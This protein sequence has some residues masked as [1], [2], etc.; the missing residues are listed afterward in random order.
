[1]RKLISNPS[2]FFLLR[3][4]KFSALLIIKPVNLWLRSFSMSSACFV[5]METRTE[6][7]LGSIRTLS[8]SFLA[9]VT[10]L[11]RSSADSLTST[12]GLLCLSTFWLEKLLRHSAA[13]S[14]L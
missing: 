2:I 9:M 14:V 4:R 1:M 8:L 11:R 6:L 7:M 12:A 10:G 3:I 5:A 13:S